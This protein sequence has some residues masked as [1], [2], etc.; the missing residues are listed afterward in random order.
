MSFVVVLNWRIQVAANLVYIYIYTSFSLSEDA[1][2]NTVGE[3]HDV[4]T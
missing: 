3:R 1:E 4:G 2:N